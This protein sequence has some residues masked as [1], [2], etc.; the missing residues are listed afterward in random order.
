MTTDTN[1]WSTGIFDCFDDKPECIYAFFCL[2]CFACNT[3]GKFGQSPWLPILDYF[4][5]VPPIALHTRFF[6]RQ[7]YGI[8]G[9]IWE[10]CLY[11]TFCYPCVWCQMS[12]EMKHHQ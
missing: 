6:M 5:S 7:R 9:S 1:Q 4:G 3:S 11:S 10:D 8:Q 12:R 2:P